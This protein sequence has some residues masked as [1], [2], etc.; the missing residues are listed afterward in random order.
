MYYVGLQ[1]VSDSGLHPV[2]WLSCPSGKAITFLLTYIGITNKFVPLKFCHLG[3]RGTDILSGP[4]NT[5]RE[6]KSFTNIDIRVVVRELRDFWFKFFQKHQIWLICP[7]WHTVSI[8]SG[9]QDKRPLAGSNFEKNQD[10]HHFSPNM[11]D[12]TS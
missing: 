12:T 11:Y 6:C 7:L 5:F 3:Y 2:T 4:W 10:G 8:F 9:R 1:C